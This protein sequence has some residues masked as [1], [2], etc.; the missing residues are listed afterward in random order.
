MHCTK[1]KT[2]QATCSAGSVSY[3]RTALVVWHICHWRRQSRD[4]NRLDSPR[5][6]RTCFV[7][8]LFDAQHSRFMA[9]SI[10]QQRLTHRGTMVATTTTTTW[11]LSWSSVH[12]S[13]HDKMTSGDQ[14]CDH[15]LQASFVASDTARAKKHWAVRPARQRRQGGE[16]AAGAPY[17]S[18]CVLQACTCCTGAATRRLRELQ[19]RSSRMHRP[20]TS[21][22]DFDGNMA[23]AHREWRKSNGNDDRMQRGTGHITWPRSAAHRQMDGWRW[24]VLIRRT[25]STHSVSVFFNLQFLRHDFIRP[26]YRDKRTSKKRTSY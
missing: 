23:A 20:T 2:E 4:K 9:D 15:C 24:K 16:G 11:Q 1:A 3:D 8:R 13:A 14:H 18:A 7:E 22:S 6:Q 10:N 12:G 19:T 17:L 25:T 21:I 26:Q 5:G